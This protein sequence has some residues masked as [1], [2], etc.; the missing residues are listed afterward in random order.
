MDYVRLSLLLMTLFA[1]LV[2]VSGQTG[3]P[4]EFLAQSWQR[5]T[6]TVAHQTLQIS[7]TQKQ[8]DYTTEVVGSSGKRY[9]LVIVPNPLPSL[10][11]EHWKIELREIILPSSVGKEV[12]GNNLLESPPADNKDYFPRED[13][14]GYLYPKNEGQINIGG[15]PW[16][17]GFP[18]YPIKATRK[19]EVEN[20]LVVIRVGS[21][22]FNRRNR[23]KL[24]YLDV[25]I[26]FMP[27][28]RA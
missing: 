17:D 1:S 21:Y 3:Q 25:F 4:H 12:T 7:L 11:L 14:I 23:N 16:M 9:E 5:G 22:Q 8:R 13:F 27:N 18:F 2:T 24:D 6:E 10:P 15:Q 28:P 20:F 26:D 19:I